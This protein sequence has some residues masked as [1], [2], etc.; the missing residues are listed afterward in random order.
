MNSYL[1]TAKTSA[2]V[3]NSLIF[4]SC[5]RAT[6][7][8]SLHARSNIW[9]LIKQYVDNLKQYVYVT[10]HSFVSKFYKKYQSSLFITKFQL[11]YS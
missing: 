1:L 2:D 5:E 10:R 8:N 4:K 6:V 7:D 9:C 3:N 11:R